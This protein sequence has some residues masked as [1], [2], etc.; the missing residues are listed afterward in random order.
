[1]AIKAKI[2]GAYQDVAG[3]FVKRS[4]VYEAVAGVFAKVGGAYGNLLIDQPLRFVSPV[5]QY[6]N[7][8]STYATTNGLGFAGRNPHWIGSGDCYELRAQLQNIAVSTGSMALPGNAHTITDVFLESDSLAKSVR[9][10]FGGQ[11]SVTLTNGQYDIQSDPILPSAFGLSKF[12]RGEKYWVR[13]MGNMPQG[14][15]LPGVRQR[16]CLPMGTSA[17]DAAGF[18]CSNIGG[19]GNLSL[20][21][22]SIFVTTHYVI[23]LL[24]RFLSGDPLTLIGCGD[25]IFQGSGDGLAVGESGQG[26]FSRALV[27]AGGSNQIGGMNFGITGGYAQLWSNKPA[28]LMA[29]V[30]YASA[31]VEE[32]G[33]NNFDGTANMSSFSM[34]TAMS[35]FTESWQ[36]LRDNKLE[37]P[38]RPFK[39]IRTLLL[40]RTTSNAAGDETPG[41]QTIFGPKWDIG[42]NVDDFHSR[43]QNT[44]IG[45]GVD[46]LCDL[47][48]ISRY[49]TDPA[50][51]NYHKWIL[52]KTSSGDGTHPSKS[53]TIALAAGLRST[54]DTIF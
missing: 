12:S 11:N 34:A 42:G 26:Y 30:K 2:A 50:T 25:S 24:G 23:G 39:I 22:N 46:L 33:T 15:K 5:N 19:T 52:G 37:H 29:H 31:A 21:G 40:P 41:S 43:L 27:G 53:M 14:G 35:W 48:A 9:V 36:G 6:P 20:T 18:T 10:T 1:M 16:Q 7:I 51:T 38:S 45:N 13:Y 28:A 47:A 8:N 44:Y 54:I 17:G 3:V 4:G 49:D 32:M